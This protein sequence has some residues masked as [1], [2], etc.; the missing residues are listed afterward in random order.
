MNANRIRYAIG[1]DPGVK[2]GV[3]VWDRHFKRFELL[4]TMG[5]LEA[6]E[7][8]RKYS[9]DTQNPIFVRIED[10]NQRKWFGANSEAKKQGAGSVKRDYKIFKDF[11]DSNHIAYH[12]VNPKD[13]KTKTDEA[14]FRA[15]TG[16]IGSTSS[17]ARDAGM[18]VY[19]F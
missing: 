2:T 6:V 4:K 11:M 5:I 1:I 17:H 12:A 3:A 9:Q 15:I 8:L 7:L 13:I 14:L 18:M 19:R 16:Y 10:P